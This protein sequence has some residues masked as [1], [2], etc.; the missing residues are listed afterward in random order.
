M[1]IQKL[2]SES[3]FEC[4]AETGG[5]VSDASTKKY[6]V[7]MH[8]SQWLGRSIKIQLFQV[9][10]RYLTAR[11]NAN[12]G[13]KFFLQPEGYT[14]IDAIDVL[15]DMLMNDWVNEQNQNNK[16]K[17]ISNVEILDIKHQANL[18]LPLEI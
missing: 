14:S 3:C 11:N 9:T 1:E 16:Y 13:H 2:F 7:S 10:Y 5:F 17:K 6:F 18:V 8:H 15:A 4:R 12:I